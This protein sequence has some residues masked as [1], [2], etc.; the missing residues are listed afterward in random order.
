M[1]RKLF[2]FAIAAVSMCVMVACGSKDAS[3]D[4]DQ[5]ATEKVTEKAE[6][7]D[8]ED[9]EEA[10]PKTEEGV[11]AL[12][13]AIYEDVN[14]I[15]GP[16][17]EDDLEPNIDLVGQYCS[18]EFRELVDKIREI[19]A[20]KGEEEFDLQGNWVG[21]WAFFDPP[22]EVQDIDVSLDGDEASVSYF[23][24]KGGEKVEMDYSVVYEDGQWRI[25]DCDRIGMLAGSWVDRMN[26]YIEANQ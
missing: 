23:L 9:G 2:L 6:S 11:V 20:N 1:K 26:D 19:D 4:K 25:S 7:D 22:F 13:N 14:I 3:K 21:L 18:K 16:R 12:I 5:N 15:C 17:G 24:K 8:S 10:A